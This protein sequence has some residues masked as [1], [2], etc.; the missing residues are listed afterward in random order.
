MSKEVWKCMRCSEN[1]M[2]L[3]RVVVHM[4]IWWCNNA[5]GIKYIWPHEG[6]LGLEGGGGLWGS[7]NC[8]AIS[9]HFNLPHPPTNSVII[10]YFIS[11]IIHTFVY[12]HYHCW[13]YITD[14]FLKM[15][16]RIFIL[17]PLGCNKHP[18]TTRRS[19]HPSTTRQQ[20]TS[21]NH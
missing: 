1:G 20:Q 16:M 4:W 5:R 14:G 13:Q 9:K 18:S 2:L 21:V 11:T 10:D 6:H 12:K 17:K 3:F 19:K 8:F 7:T 15:H